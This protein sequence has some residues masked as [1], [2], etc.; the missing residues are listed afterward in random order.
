MSN[1][2]PAANSVSS[3]SFETYLR[4]VTPLAFALAL[5]FCLW[6]IPGA[7]AA[8]DAAREIA[9]ENPSEAQLKEMAVEV[10]KIMGRD[11]SP[12]ELQK[13]IK[14]LEKNRGKGRGFWPSPILPGKIPPFHDYLSFM[15]CEVRCHQSTVSWT[16]LLTAT[17]EVMDKWI[18]DCE[19]AGLNHSDALKMIAKGNIVVKYDRSEKA[20]AAEGE[21]AFFIKLE[22]VATYDLWPPEFAAVFPRYESSGGLLQAFVS[23]VDG[24]PRLT[25]VYVCENPIG[26]SLD[27]YKKVL[28]KQGFEVTEIGGEKCLAR[29]D[30]LYVGDHRDE[31]GLLTMEWTITQPGKLKK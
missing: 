30:L 22:I 10:S 3:G 11:I 4:R 8:E 14:D 23:E 7:S 21:N 24:V 16:I 26:A 9:A 27:D 29:G 31:N 17:P 2:T 1:L 19:V 13:R 18:K 20:P 5:I 12:E 28:S 25:R 15:D 6:L